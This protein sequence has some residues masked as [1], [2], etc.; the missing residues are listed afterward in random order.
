M[1]S[2]HAE[3]GPGFAGTWRQASSRSRFRENRCILTY[4]SA[5]RNAALANTLIALLSLGAEC[6]RFGVVLIRMHRAMQ[7]LSRGEIS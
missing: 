3:V 4:G 5:A 2:A 6:H 1:G 7:A